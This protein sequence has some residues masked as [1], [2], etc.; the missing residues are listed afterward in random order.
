MPDQYFEGFEEK[1]LAALA[2]K[3]EGKIFSIKT[4]DTGFN[5]PDQY[6]ENFERKILTTIADKE[7]EKIDFCKVKKPGFTVPNQYFETLE[8]T[9]STKIL[10]KESTTKVIS[11][12]V[13]KKLIYLS[14]IATMIVL[15]VVLWKQEQTSTLDFDSIAISDI[16]EYIRNGNIEVSDD[17]LAVLLDTEISLMESFEDTHLSDEDLENYLLKEDLYN[18]IYIE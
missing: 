7:Q 9:L 12:P 1:L 3:E 8:R 16:Q 4:K 14:G 13:V 10:K 2:D 11:I 6:F 18:D 17:E 15:A 5:I